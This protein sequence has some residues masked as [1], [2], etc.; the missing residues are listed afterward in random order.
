MAA[1][2]DGKIYVFGGYK[3][4]GLRNRTKRA[5]VLRGGEWK[6]LPNMPAP[7]A[8]GGAAPAKGKIYVVGGTAP[9]GLAQKTF[10]FDPDE[11]TWDRTAG[12]NT[13]REHM[14]VTSHEG[15]VYGIGGR[16]GGMTNNLDAA[17]RFNPRTGRWRNLRAL[18]TARGGL[19]AAATGNGLLVAPGGEEHAGTFEEVEAYNTRTERWRTLPDMDTPRHGLGVVAVGNRVFTLAGGPQ[20]GGSFSDT[21]EVINLSDP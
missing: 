20:P 14:G 9:G 13:P 3:G 8:A 21:N 4:P 10:V 15:F 19:A 5:F 16:A 18:P 12:L 6:T 17:E 7:R 2:F 1:S 11:K